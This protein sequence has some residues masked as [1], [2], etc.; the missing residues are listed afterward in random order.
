[1]I[2]RQTLLLLCSFLL[3]TGCEKI[4]GG[5][6]DNEADWENGQGQLADQIG[7]PNNMSKAV[8]PPPYHYFLDYIEVIDITEYHM[9]TSKWF[10]H[11]DE[12]KFGYGLPSGTMEA[13]AAYTIKLFPKNNENVQMDKDV[14]IQLTTRDQTYKQSELIMEDMI[15]L[16][17]I[18]KEEEIYSNQLPEKKNVVYVLSVE[19][20]DQQHQVEDTMV[21]MIYVPTPEINAKLTTDKVVYEQSDEKVIIAIKN[22]G[23]TF[24]SIGEDY[25]V[26]KKVNDRWKVVPLDIAF[27]DIGVLI[28]IDDNFEQ[29]IAINQLTPGKYRVIK[30]FN[31]DGLDLS[32]TLAAEFSV[33]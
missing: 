2:K 30:T 28:N 14:R 20:L 29:T 12:G 21:S 31:A 25:T 22:Y 10:I 6:L 26:E 13:G 7:N 33:K 23:P 24:L 32:A 19:I 5:V 3:I 1:M 18:N 9:P 8:S 17:T 11:D 4:N 27:P 16:D 15:H